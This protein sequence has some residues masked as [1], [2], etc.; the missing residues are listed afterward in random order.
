MT[1]CPQCFMREPDIVSEVGDGWR[2]F[3]C[4]EC[5]SSWHERPIN[6]RL[7]SEGRVPGGV[8]RTYFVPEK[9]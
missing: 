6:E 2:L 4:R 5:G 7:I 8:I 3:Y 9:E 1:T